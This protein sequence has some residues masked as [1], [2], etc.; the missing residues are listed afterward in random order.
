M[1]MALMLL[2]LSAFGMSA[3]ASD[4]RPIALQMGG[5]QA[6]EVFRRRITGLRIAFAGWVFGERPAES[7]LQ[8]IRFAGGAAD[9][10]LFA[11]IGRPV[12]QGQAPLARP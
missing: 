6:G 3:Q 4:A 5:L 12:T 11:G 8:R 9:D 7:C 2:L 10:P 1:L